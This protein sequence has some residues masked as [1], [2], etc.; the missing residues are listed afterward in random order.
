VSGLRVLE[1]FASLQ[2]EGHWTGTPMTFVRLAGCNAPELRLGCLPW[3]DTPESWDPAAGEELTV[4]EI[5]R[6]PPLPRLCI[7]GGEP[8]LQLEGVLDLSAEAHR[9]EMRVHVETNGTLDPPVGAAESFDWVA[10][11]PKPPDY[12]IAEGWCGL[13]DELKM[14]ADDSLD[15]AG[16]ERLAAAHP[17]AVVFIQP[18]HGT[19]AERA[20][21]LVMEHPEWRL[22]L[23]VHK[24]LGIR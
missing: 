17:E 7:T 1:V 12:L 19:S 24:I 5:M 21:A 15:A 11:S 13:V 10:V 6:R 4:G 20:V 22:S 14:V 16:A 3:C 9:R 8:L 23:Q 2:G 18:V